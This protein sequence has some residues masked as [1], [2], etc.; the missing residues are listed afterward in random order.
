MVSREYITAST[1]TA[2]LKSKLKHGPKMSRQMRAE[3]AAC[4]VDAPPR[5]LRPEVA[6]KIRTELARLEQS[7]NPGARRFCAAMRDR[8]PEI[9]RTEVEVSL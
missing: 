3:F 8:Y 7:A 6:N 1:E 9:L 2:R 5:R 4:Q